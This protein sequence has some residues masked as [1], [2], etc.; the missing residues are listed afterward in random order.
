MNALRKV[1]AYL[2]DRL[3][4]RSTWLLFGAAVSAAAALEWPWSLIFCVIGII[5]ALVPNPPSK[6]GGE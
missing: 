2:R 5:G 4:E 3:D 6:D 1:W